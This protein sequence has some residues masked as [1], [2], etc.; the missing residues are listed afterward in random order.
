MHGGPYTFKDNIYKHKIE[1]TS[2]GIQ[3][4]LLGTEQSLTA[5]V[6]GES[7]DVTGVLTNGVR[8]NETWTR[9]AKRSPEQGHEGAWEG[10]NPRQP[11]N[12]RSVKL[13]AGN[14]FVITIYDR[15]SRTT[16]AVIGGTCN[17]NGNAYTE[18]PEYGSPALQLLG[19]RQSLTA[20]VQADQMDITGVLT[21]GLKVNDTWRRIK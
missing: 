6:R 3:A 14:Q 7:M 18:T 20:Q 1:Y 15:N 21:N 12:L 4:T 9:L 2:P 17:L 10:V 16:L 5:K 11:P 19:Q 13:I 8:I